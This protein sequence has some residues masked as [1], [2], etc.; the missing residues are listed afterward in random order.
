MANKKHA[1]FSR[2]S[3]LILSSAGATT[4]AFASSALGR[5][6]VNLLDPGNPLVIPQNFKPS[7]Q[8]PNNEP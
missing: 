8:L 1:E 4:M 5:E 6:A 2:R 3:F 7:M